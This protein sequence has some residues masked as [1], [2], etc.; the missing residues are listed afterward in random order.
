[1]FKF[2]SVFLKDAATRFNRIAR[3]VRG[4]IKPA[5]L[6]ADAWMV[7]AE[8]AEKRGREIDFSNPVDQELVLNR[9]YWNVKDQRDWRLA[10][11]YSI[12]DDREGS[13]PWA[14]RLAAPISASP[15]EILLQH[16]A[17][18][19]IDSAMAASYSQAAAYTVA[20]TNFDSDP[21]QLSAHLAISEG[22]LKQRMSKAV[23]IVERQNSM[24]DGFEKIDPAFKPH[25]GRKLVSKE[26][27]AVEAEQCELTF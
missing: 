22:A 23:E 15:L 5:D 4:H 13:T 11:A 8:I 1:M 27:V 16:E 7:A 14:D 20:L 10:S 25:P 3:S 9:V 21:P 2:F 12:D 6:H 18:A 24:F 19:M 26:E 17:A